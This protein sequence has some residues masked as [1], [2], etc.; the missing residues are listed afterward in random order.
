ME[1]SGTAAEKSYAYVK[2]GDEEN[3]SDDQLPIDAVACFDS[4]G[5][6][7]CTVLCARK[8]H[9]AYSSNVGSGT[10]DDDQ[11]D[12][13]HDA[14]ANCLG[15]D[16]F[17]ICNAK[18]PNVHGDNC[19]EVVGGQNV[20]GLVA[21]DKSAADGVLCIVG[22]GC[23]KKCRQFYKDAEKGYGN[24]HQQDRRHDLPEQVF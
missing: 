7:F 6:D 2:A 10:V 8:I 15:S 14:G 20:H 24:Q 1:E 18:G 4:P 12:T 19:A 5:Q 11:H 17:F 16:C 13:G 23:G 22:I 21:G 9:T 3:G